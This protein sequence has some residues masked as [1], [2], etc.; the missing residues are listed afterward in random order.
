ML[1]SLIWSHFGGDQRNEMRLLYNRD[2]NA[3]SMYLFDE[4]Q[5][6][7]LGVV[8]DNLLLILQV[9]LAASIISKGGKGESAV[10]QAS[11]TFAMILLL[12]FV[13]ICLALSV[14]GDFASQ[15][16]EEWH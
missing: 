12:V 16:I 8:A 10:S 2:P 13:L 4:L 3:E 14:V 9:V 11:M 5:G 1:Y 7:N 15:C 6:M